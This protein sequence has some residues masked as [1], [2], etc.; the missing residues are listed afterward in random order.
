[1][2]QL[3][4]HKKIFEFIK[5]GLETANFEY[6]KN[7]L[8]KND[9]AI[10]YFYANIDKSW[11]KKLQDNGF[12]EVLNKKAE[13]ST[14]YAYRMPELAYL[15]NITESAPEQVADV[16]LATKTTTENFNPEVIERFLWITTK[17]P[18]DQLSRVVEK[19]KND[20]WIKLMA[21]FRKTGYEFSEMVETL[22]KASD[23]DGLI[24]LAQAIMIVRDEK[25][26]KYRE[27]I[28]Y[29]TELYTSGIFEI[30]SKI[31]DSDKVKELSKDLILQLR[32]TIKNTGT[33]YEQ[34][35]YIFEY[36][37][38]FGLYDSDLFTMKVESNKMQSFH[39]DEKNFVALLMN[40]LRKVSVN[41]APDILKLLNE[42]P[43]S[44][45]S[46]K[47]HLVFLVN[48]KEVF[49]SEIFNIMS[50]LFELNDHYYAIFSGS[51]YK[52]AAG[53]VFPDWTKEQQNGYIQKLVAF[54]IKQKENHPD[55]DWHSRNAVQLL[56]VLSASIQDKTT[57]DLLEKY[58]QEDFG[59]PINESYKPEPSIH[60]EMAGTVQH[61]SPFDIAT[62]NV[63]DI[64]NHLKS[65]WSPEKLKE[66]YR[67]KVMIIMII[68]N[69]KIRLNRHYKTH[70][71]ITFTII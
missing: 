71:N 28:F 41:D 15:T 42:L 65:D 69:L 59:I 66:E 22:K 57:K 56:S 7:E 13:D 29:V 61:R 47:I 4:L 70:I 16:I 26:D 30:L 50:Y 67:T 14:T 17:L 48:H 39:A 64:F 54:F 36:E 51:E 53:K 55:Q 37:D 18:A 46:W 10:R 25:G 35:K 8:F 2:N 20:Q 43:P 40:L 49:V 23:W 32:N 33:K 38:P 60:S 52:E 5:A 6:L 62:F 34:G 31:Y 45:L 68:L 63:S 12:F 3:E 19:M 58:A 44:R 1:M 9:D 24:N 21:R 27:G 11:A